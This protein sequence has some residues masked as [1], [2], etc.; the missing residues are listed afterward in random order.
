MKVTTSSITVLIVLFCASWSMAQQ[1]P[2][3]FEDDDGLCGYADDDKKVVIPAKYGFCADFDKSGYAY[4]ITDEDGLL[5]YIDTK[6][7]MLWQ[8][9]PFDF[10]P[11]LSP[12]E[13]SRFME[14]GKMGY[15]GDKQT[16]VVPAKYDFIGPFEHDHALVCNDCK[17][18]IIEELSIVAEGTW[19]VIDFTGKEIVSVTKNQEEAR[20]KA[21]ELRK[22]IKFK[23]PQV[24]EEGDLFGY[25]DKGDKI[26]IPAQYYMADD[27]DRYGHAQ[28]I[29]KDGCFYIATT[30]KTVLEA[31][32]YDNGPDYFSDGLAR[33]IKDGK[34]GYHDRELNIVIPAKFDFAE[35]F[36]NGRASF[37]NSCT[38]EQDGEHSRMVG[39]TWGVIDLKG[40]E[41]TTDSK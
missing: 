3:V 24:F 40:K 5:Y 4:I 19:G 2:L 17:E 1:M 11:E 6:G 23:F 10:D 30:G 27:F 21:E 8:P 7:K 12:D 34:M 15:R 29:S 26:V 32:N 16:P 28:I 25:K 38:T 20:L 35:P 37:C 33:F 18:K 31:F 41:V 9:L 22:I 39:G 36:E 13:F 14:N